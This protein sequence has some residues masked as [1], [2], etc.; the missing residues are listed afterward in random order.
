M[1][2]K[3]SVF[4]L[5]LSCVVALITMLTLILKNTTPQIITPSWPLLLLFFTVT[6]I[7]IYFMAVKVKSKNDINKMTNFQ[8]LVTIVKLVVCLAIIA[9]YSIMFT[10]TA[11]AFVILFLV[12]YL[13]FTFFETFVKIKIN[14]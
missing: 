8:M 14:N 3:H 2:S 1:K 10:E 4:F 11:R 5:S 12:Y 6:N 13:C 9:T 7:L